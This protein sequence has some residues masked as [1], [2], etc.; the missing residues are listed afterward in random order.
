MMSWVTVGEIVIWLLLAAGLGVVLGWLLHELWNRTRQESPD[1]PAVAPPANI[2]GN[3]KSMIYHL[4]G[5][6][7][8]ERTRSD[9]W[10][11]TEEEARGAGYRKPKN[12]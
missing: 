8:Y 1:K 6:P 11:T 9:V 12:Q 3:S 7:L 5:S 10:F 4:P 2:K